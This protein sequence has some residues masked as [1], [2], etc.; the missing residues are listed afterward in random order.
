MSTLF[1]ALMEAA[2][3][4]S[5]KLSST[6]LESVP[7]RQV[8]Q[9]QMQSI[10]RKEQMSVLL[11]C[12]LLYIFFCN[13]TPRLHSRMSVHRDDRDKANIFPVSLSIV[14]LRPAIIPELDHPV[15]R[16]SKGRYE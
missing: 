5:C 9:N 11:R 7:H 3:L 10:S 6:V 4:P 8:G 13:P 12:G 2:S 15:M 14:T 1:Q 16:G